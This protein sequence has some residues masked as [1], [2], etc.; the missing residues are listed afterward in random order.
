M[1]Q[2]PLTRRLSR[3]GLAVL[4]VSEGNPDVHI[5]LARYHAMIGDRSAALSYLQFALERRPDDGH[6]NVIGA[7]GLQRIG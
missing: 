7:D 5:L 1:K 6:Y 3:Q 2:G 4:D